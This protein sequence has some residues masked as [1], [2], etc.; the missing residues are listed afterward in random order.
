VVR[1]PDPPRCRARVE[2]APAEPM[3]VAD[4]PARLGPRT[5]ASGGERGRPGHPGLRRADR[6]R[7]AAACGR[8][9]RANHRHGW[10]KSD[11]TSNGGARA[12]GHRGWEWSGCEPGRA[13]GHEPPRHRTRCRARP[14]C[15]RTG[16][17]TAGQEPGRGSPAEPPVTPLV[18]LATESGEAAMVADTL[19]RRRDRL[20]ALG[21]DVA[22][23]G[24]A[25]PPGRSDPGGADPGGADRLLVF[26]VDAQPPDEAAADMARRLDA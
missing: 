25:G 3:G 26:G 18:H 11:R 23:P 9:T 19:A 13:A 4:H 15:R 2:A 12:A 10:R 20:A 8:A 17:G 24:P 1:E 6:R 14:A 7:H 5:V 16:P 22:D 21:V